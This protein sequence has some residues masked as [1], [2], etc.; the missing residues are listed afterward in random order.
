MTD[1]MTSQVVDVKGTKRMRPDKKP[2]KSNL[3]LNYVVSAA[4]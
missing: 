4:N 2:V 3:V 1:P